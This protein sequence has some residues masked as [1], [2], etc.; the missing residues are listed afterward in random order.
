[1]TFSVSGAS[2][3]NASPLLTTH[4]AT[5]EA[6]VTASIVA[7]H[8]CQDD[9]APTCSVSSWVSSLAA[10]LAQAPALTGYTR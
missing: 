1:M 2:G 9:N 10:Q 5:P 3:Y 6:L 7:H 4:S 8:F